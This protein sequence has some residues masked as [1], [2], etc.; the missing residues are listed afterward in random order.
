MYATGDLE[1]SYHG[2]NWSLRNTT[3]GDQI[4]SFPGTHSVL[5]PELISSPG[6]M[7]GRRGSNIHVRCETLTEESLDPDGPEVH[8]DCVFQVSGSA[9]F[10]TG[11]VTI[12]V[13][14]LVKC[15]RLLEI[16][17]S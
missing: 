9:I 2:D 17:G 4:V 6:V 10:V 13:D 5:Y 1:L 11:L 8:L 15:C 3:S 16:T 7:G 14:I 12:L